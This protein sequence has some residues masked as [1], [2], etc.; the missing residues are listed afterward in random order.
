[1]L[2]RL[3]ARHVNTF[4]ETSQY[5]YRNIA[6]HL[7]KHRNTFTE[8]SQYIYRN[9]AIHLQKHRNTFTETSIMSLKIYDLLNNNSLLIWLYIITLLTL[10]QF[11]SDKSHIIHKKE[12]IW[13]PQCDMRDALKMRQVL[14]VTLKFWIRRM[15]SASIMSICKLFTKLVIYRM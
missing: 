13:A 11:K 12:K 14:W 3:I 8:T 1:M 9:I 15:R 2:D 10:C 5:I 6:I 4:T 7:Q